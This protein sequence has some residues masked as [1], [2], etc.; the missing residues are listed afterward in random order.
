M[1]H[2]GVGGTPAAQGGDG[3]PQ[4][5]P[6]ADLSQPPW[7]GR[8]LKAKREEGGRERDGLDSITDL[9]DMNLRKFQDSE[10]QKAWHAGVYA[11]PAP[12][13]HH[14]VFCY[15]NSHYSRTSYKRNHRIFDF[16]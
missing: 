11:L 9:M 15:Y 10:A 4:G 12:G 6:P 2:S 3:E 13:N 5:L 1:A 14:S 8:G 7:L 16:L